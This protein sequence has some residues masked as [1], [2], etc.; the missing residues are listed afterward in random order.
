VGF[1]R[2]IYQTPGI[3]GGSETK[4]LKYSS[5]LS[6]ISS[7]D[8][9]LS[10]GHID[11]YYRRYEAAERQYKKAF[12]VAYSKVSCQKLANLYKNK[13][14]EPERNNLGRIQQEK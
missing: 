3:V 5:E 2:I 6:K 13:M 8:G 9:Y 12:S 11:E 10:R 7:V 1:D 4:A 14:N